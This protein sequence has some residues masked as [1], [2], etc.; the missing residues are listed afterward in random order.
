MSGSRLPRRLRSLLR[1]YYLHDATVTFV[2]VADRILHLTIQLDAPPKDTIFLRYRL[3]SEV[4]MEAHL[5][6]GHDGT[7]P[8]TWLYDEL[9]IVSEGAF[10]VIEQRI[11]LSNGLEL[12]IHFQDLSYTTARA[13]P[14]AS[15]I[16]R[17][18]PPPILIGTM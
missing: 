1:R 2:G 14:M 17:R 15:K 11:L 10:P 8:L 6:E 3:A 7:E 12:T 18:V 5:L 9:D 4:R 16:F 13:M